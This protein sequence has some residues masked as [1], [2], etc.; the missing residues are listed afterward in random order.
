MKMFIKSDTYIKKVLFCIMFFVDIIIMAVGI[1]SNNISRSLIIIT[2]IM[3]IYLF[4][5]ILYMREGLYI[6]H[7]TLCYKGVRKRFYNINDIARIHIVTTQICLG[8]NR[9]DSSYHNIG[10]KDLKG[11]YHY[12]ILYLN[13]KNIKMYDNDDGELDFYFNHKDSV[14]F[15]SEYDDR[16]IKLF[17]SRGV[18]ITGRI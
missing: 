13:N 17:E 12:K 4:I 6:D 14:L 16:V 5:I 7:D 2:V 8:Y 10:V 11:N 9:F 18:L 1:R 3:A 15:S